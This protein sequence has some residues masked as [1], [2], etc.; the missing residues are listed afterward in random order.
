LPRRHAFATP[1]AKLVF[2]ARHP[3]KASTTPTTGELRLPFDECFDSLEV[4]VKREAMPL[5]HFDKF[6]RH[7]VSAGLREI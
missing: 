7:A 1:E 4:S 6:V 2:T 5:E 3:G